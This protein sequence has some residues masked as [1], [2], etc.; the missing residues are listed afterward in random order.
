MEKAKGARGIGPNAVGSYDRNN[1][2]SDLGISKQQSSDW[3]KLAG[4]IED[5][6]G[7]AIESD[8]AWCTLNTL[9]NVVQDYLML[10]G[11]PWRCRHMKTYP[12]ETARARFSKLFERALAGEP[13]R[14]TRYGKDA[15]VI[16]SEKQWQERPR[17]AESLGA[18]LAEFARKGA[19]GEDIAH[20]PWGERPLS[21]DG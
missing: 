6:L 5:E 13:Q 16:V 21:F 2:L 1:S 10:Y 14:V 4:L 9:A 17:R 18:L 7:A 15:V 11:V 12:I 20:R 3:Q 8:V 19:A